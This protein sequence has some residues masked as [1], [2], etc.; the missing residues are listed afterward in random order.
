MDLTTPALEKRG[1]DALCGGEAN[2][3][4][5]PFP[6]PEKMTSPEVRE[7]VKM[8]GNPESETT[9][10]S[11]SNSSSPSSTDGRALPRTL[12][13]VLQPGICCVVARRGTAVK[14]PFE[15]GLSLL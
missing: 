3:K 5:H 15:F 11:S 7:T 8:E 9:A 1:C 13:G 2:G 6:G 10:E 14:F 12:P 4:E